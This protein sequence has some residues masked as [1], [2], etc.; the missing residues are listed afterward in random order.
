MAVVDF[1]NH[2]IPRVDDGASS[3]DEAAVALRAF[4]AQDI[5]EI[6]ATPHVNGSLTLRSEVIAA[7]LREID[8]GWDRLQSIALEHV[9]G[10]RIHRGA[11]VMLDT[12]EP[13]LSDERLRLAGTCFAL[14]EYPFMTVPPNSTGVLARIITTGVTPIIAHPERYVGVDTECRLASQWRSAG[15]LL[16]VNAGS[17]TGRYGEHA[18]SNALALLENGLA[19]YICSDF[20][21][22]GRPATAAAQKVLLDGGGAEHMELLT[23]VNPR[24]MLQGELPLP[25]PPLQLTLS[26]KD[27]LRRWLR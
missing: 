25:L 17:I 26:V 5:S 7:R 20:H 22:R 9:P 12:P 23:R 18:R 3:D 24:R 16:Q 19:D 4:L 1:H 21:S 27:R 15:A 11:E 6:V 10:M 14:C 8:Q 2:V 13:D